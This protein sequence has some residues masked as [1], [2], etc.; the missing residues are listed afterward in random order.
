MDLND[1]S[2]QEQYDKYRKRLEMAKDI[3]LDDVEAFLQDSILYSLK[4]SMIFYSHVYKLKSANDTYSLKLCLDKHK[5][6]DMI[7][8][9]WKIT[10]P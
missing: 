10:E 8:S 9:S 5:D 6:K 4:Y 2:L 1:G 7:S 3:T